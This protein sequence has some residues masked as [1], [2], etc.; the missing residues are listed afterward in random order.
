MVM[1]AAEEQARNMKLTGIYLWTESWQAPG[2]YKKLGYSQFVE[3][4]NFP[5]GHSRLG[6]CK[7]L[8]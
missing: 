2:F 8:T 6:F 5:P 4:R 3:F 1:L 7:Y